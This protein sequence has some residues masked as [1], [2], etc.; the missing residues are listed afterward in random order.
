MIILKLIPSR[1]KEKKNQ[2]PKVNKIALSREFPSF[3][4]MVIKDIYMS[5]HIVISGV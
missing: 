1:Q 2:K 4:E 3:S 5:Y